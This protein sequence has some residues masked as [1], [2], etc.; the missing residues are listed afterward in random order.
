MGSFACKGP[1]TANKRNP[2]STMWAG[3]GERSVDDM[4]QL[5]L[6]LVYLDDAEYRAQVAER[7]TKVQQGL[8]GS[9]QQQ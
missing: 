2:D 5:R 7:K 4:L 6:A 9:N 1:T 8:T 3:Y